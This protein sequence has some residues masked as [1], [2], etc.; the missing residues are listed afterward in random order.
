LHA[1]TGV[2]RGFFAKPTNSHIIQGE[3]PV[4]VD[5]AILGGGLAGVTVASLLHRQ[6]IDTAVLEREP[7]IGGL[8]RSFESD[9]FT[10][11][12]GGSH[13]IFS[14]DTEVLRFMQDAL[15]KNQD[16]RIRNTRILYRDRFVKYPFEN[17]LADLPPEDRFF[18]LNEFVRTL[19]DAECGR[20]PEPD[21]FRDWM[22]ATFG[23][24][25]AESYLIP[26]NT[27]IWNCPP[28][29][30][31]AHWMEGRVPRPPVEDIIRSAVGIETEGYIHQSRFTYPIHGGIVSLVRGIAEPVRDAIRTGFEVR[32]LRRDHEEWI[33]SNGDEEIRA[34]RVV[35]TIPLQHLLRCLVGVPADVSR[36]CASLR[37]N[38]LVCACIGIRG[39]VPP[40]SWVYVP[41]EDILCNRVSFP[42]NYSTGVAPP[43]HA[44]ILAEITCN[45]G[46][47]VDMMDDA[48]ITDRVITDLEGVGLIDDRSD[49]VF[50]RIERQPF[51]YV[52]Y[53]HEYLANIAIV[54][55]YCRSQGI[56]L[57]GRF[58]QFE[59]LNMD[60]VI[61][62]AMDHVEGR[63]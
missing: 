41:Q 24:G 23:K 50:S 56:D 29:E 1:T 44:S 51:A 32:S 27:K 22:Y 39:T 61:R 60:G 9:G 36:A 62:S 4:T 37:Y 58:A 20:L 47:A 26:Y 2:W 15:G 10:F 48:A 16:Q 28:E 6:G 53:D 13:I 17:G 49:V 14:R 7:E 40:Y 43:G 42:S 63:S 46:D 3:Q 21:N 12:R 45:T 33:I 59:Y 31:S 55:E 38:S 5:C 34:R 19:I 35:S 54:R 8:C 30:M 25:I 52:V 18:C 57:V 11:D